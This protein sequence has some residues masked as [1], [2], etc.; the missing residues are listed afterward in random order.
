M[1]AE[2]EEIEFGVISH[3]CTQMKKFRRGS[4]YGTNKKFNKA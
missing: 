3:R 1:G 2:K 4:N